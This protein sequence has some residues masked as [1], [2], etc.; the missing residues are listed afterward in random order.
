MLGQCVV[1]CQA[2]GGAVIVGE[3]GWKGHGWGSG[4]MGGG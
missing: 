2:D 1:V 4:G 3:E